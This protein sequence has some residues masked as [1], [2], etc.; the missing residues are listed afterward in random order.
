MKLSQVGWNNQLSLYG[1]GK[2]ES[3]MLKGRQVW[4]R[5]RVGAEASTPCDRCLAIGMDQS[6][7][8]KEGREKGFVVCGTMSEAVHLVSQG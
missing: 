8:M 6:V 5:M 3:S 4:G 2:K 1:K 7:Y